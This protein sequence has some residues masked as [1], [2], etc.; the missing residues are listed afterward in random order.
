MKYYRLPMG[1]LNANCYVVIDEVTKKA[2]VIDPSSYNSDLKQVLHSDEVS[3]VEYI[4]LTHGHFDHILGVPQVKED[5]KNAKICIHEEDEKNL[6]NKDLNL[7]DMVGLPFTPIAADELL[8]D[9]SIIDLG[10]LKIKVMHTPGHTQG[11]VCY[12]IEDE[13][14]IFSGD[15]LFRG[16]FGRTDFPGGDSFKLI[17]SLK[18]LKN[19]DGDYKIL[20][21]HEN[22]TTLNY[23][24]EHNMYM[25]KL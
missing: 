1:P 21:G 16:S 4:L 23:E 7:V 18:R 22:D 24:R 10:T 25:R 3:S 20:P 17:Q 2:A 11:G 14:I 8:E 19:L 6:S 13:K 9:G 15:T 12:I 5:F